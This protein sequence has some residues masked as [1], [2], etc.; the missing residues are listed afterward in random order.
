MKKSLS[1]VYKFETW[2]EV[3]Q[4]ARE[5]KGD[6]FYYNGYNGTYEPIVEV[7]ETTGQVR[8]ASDWGLNW[9]LPAV[10]EDCSSDKSSPDIPIENIYGYDFI[11]EL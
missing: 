1:I 4:F 2:E 7:I 11:A 6:L 10:T 8:L 5:S 3:C 9:V